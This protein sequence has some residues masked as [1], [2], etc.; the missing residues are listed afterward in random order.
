MIEIDG[1]MF[2]SRGLDLR[3]WLRSCTAMHPKN[4]LRLC[5][6]DAVFNFSFLSSL[7]RNRVNTR[8]T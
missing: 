8:S 4:S 1:L 7:R 3:W 5:L 6:A 2:E